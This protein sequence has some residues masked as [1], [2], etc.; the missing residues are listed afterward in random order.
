[1]RR[2]ARVQ[3][4]RRET[5]SVSFTRFF[6]TNASSASNL[7]NMAE[8]EETEQMILK[9][10]KEK[11]EQME[12]FRNK[13]GRGWTDEWGIEEM[14][15][16]KTTIAD[17]PQW[18]KKYISRIT[19]ERLQ[20]TKTLTLAGLSELPLPAAT[21]IHPAT[22][23]K[24]FALSRL[25]R[26]QQIVTDSVREL[27]APK[28]K[29]IQR[30]QNWEAKQTAVDVLFEEI[31]YE[32]KQQMVILGKHPEF[33]LW[34]EGAL[35]TY[36]K[37]MQPKDPSPETPSATNG[38]Q[39]ATAESATATTSDTESSDD[40]AVASAT[41]EDPDKS[42][43]P[44]FL[45]C[46]RSDVD[47]KEDA[48]PSILHPLRPNPKRHTE[49]RM[50]EEWELAADRTSRRIMI[51]Q[52]TRT[53]AK[54]LRQGNPVV[55]H[56][57]Q[58]TGK[59]AALAAIVATA[60]SS[61]DTVVLYIQEVDNMTQNCFYVEP[62]AR[63]EGYYDL[64][65]LQAQ[66][67]GDLL[68]SHERE[69]EAFN[70][71][72][73]QLKEYCTETQLT[74]LRK[75][76][77]LD[78]SS[79]VAILEY[80]RDHN[81]LAPAIYRVAIDIL[82]KQDSLDFYMV[83]DEF[84]CLFPPKGHIFHEHYDFSVEKSIPHDRISLFEPIMNAMGLKALPNEDEEDAAAPNPTPIQRGGVVVATTES[85]AIP[86]KVTDAFI[87]MAK[88]RV[89]VVEIP[90]LSHLEV[91]HM[92]SHYEAVGIGKLRLDQGETVMNEQEVSYLKMVSGG[93][94]Q[95]LMNACM[96]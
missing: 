12:F 11:E 69:L 64:P 62:S 67:C 96:W 81:S 75:N 27:A 90:R 46:F 84:N 91:E 82:M 49:G 35:E 61:E 34:V 8:Q 30:L 79:L 73:E 51:R 86:R 28:I 77:P 70:V 53:I 94:A 31:E 3:W 52:S 4:L 45:D 80:G 18:E 93:E 40:A 44:I 65:V 41:E 21:T 23:S 89:K 72:D 60:R 50:V 15:E 48:V 59:T 92:L 20:V 19:N 54:E 88:D 29:E 38:E 74:R 43:V 32:L 9:K 36:L 42:A 2:V 66:V 55:V 85:H 17:L 56:G 13:K 95:H 7:Y 76:V 1:M 47:S 58:G 6:S 5:I 87:Q 71:T 26:H 33:G 78:K 24:L 10:K 25:R 22:S 14:L 63:R 57:R 37:E 83:M 39:D 16:S 68:K